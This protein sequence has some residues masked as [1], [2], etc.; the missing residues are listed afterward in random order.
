MIELLPAQ[1]DRV[2]RAAADG[3]SMPV[4][5][6]GLDR[7]RGTLATRPAQLQD[8]RLSRSLL[9]GLLLVASL[10]G[11]GSYMGNAQLAR[12]LDMNVSTVHRYLQT[13]VAVGLVERDPGT[14][15]YRLAQ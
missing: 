11:D 8:P 7:V 15:R 1:V 14:R 10:P 5:L 13:L 6:A 2:V 3:G 12:M 9:S 4:L